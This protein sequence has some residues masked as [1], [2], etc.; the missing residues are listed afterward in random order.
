M[1]LLPTDTFISDEFKSLIRQ[2]RMSFHNRRYSNH[3]RQDA[4]QLLTELKNLRDNNES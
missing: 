1:K 2:L 4:H 3:A